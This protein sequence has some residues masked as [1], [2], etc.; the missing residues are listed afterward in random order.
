MALSDAS[1]SCLTSSLRTLDP[2][3]IDSMV[4]NTADFGNQG[5]KYQTRS[6]LADEPGLG[7]LPHRNLTPTSLQSHCAAAAVGCQTQPPHGPFST[8]LRK[9][10][11]LLHKVDCKLSPTSTTYT[12]TNTNLQQLP[13]AVIHDLGNSNYDSSNRKKKAAGGVAPSEPADFD[14]DLTSQTSSPNSTF[15]LPPQP[16]VFDFD[17]ATEPNLQ[18]HFAL[19]RAR[20]AMAPILPQD[21]SLSQTL[22]LTS[23]TAALCPVLPLPSATTPLFCPQHSLTALQPS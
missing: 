8:S 19:K 15:D 23:N 4:M 17:D 20:H 10:Q 6:C 16:S 18:P 5:N 13:S 12:T 21:H 3:T 2:Y 9:Q 11:H 22:S 7:H 1:S 14:I